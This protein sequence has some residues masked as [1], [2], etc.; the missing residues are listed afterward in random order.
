[1]F[2]QKAALLAVYAVLL[3]AA[4]I[5]PFALQ[6]RTSKSPSAWTIDRV[7]GVALAVAGLALLATRPWPGLT[8]PLILSIA[9]AAPLVL[10]GAG[11]AMA[12]GRLRACARRSLMRP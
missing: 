12:I 2:E 1:M 10:S 8:G 9:F 7:Y 5:L 11:Y 4:C 6:L 3:F